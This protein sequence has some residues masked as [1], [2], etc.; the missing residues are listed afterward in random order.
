LNLAGDYMNISVLG[1]TG[2]VGT[3]TL[4]VA[5]ELKNCRVVGISG[6]K[7]I[8]LLED[9]IRKFRPQICAVADEKLA[10]ELKIKVS[11]TG[12]KVIDGEPGVCEV[13]SLDA[14][15]L[16]VCAI[17]GIA[18]LVPLLRAINSK[19]TV[20]IANK[21]PL[22]AAGKI[23]MQAARDNSVQ[24]LPLDSE[25]SAIFQ[26]LEGNDKSV[27]EKIILTA[28]GGPFFGKSRKELE[29]VTPAEAL[30]H[31]N[32][33]MGK[34][35]TIDSATLMNKGFEIIEAFWLF[36]V[37]KIE[38]IVHRESIIHSMVEFVD[39]TIL[40]QLGATSMKGPIRHALTYPSRVHVNS[41]KLDF[42]TISK[43]SFS[44]PDEKT[45]GCLKLAR[46]A[47]NLGGIMPAVLNAADEVAV[48]KFLAGEIKFLDI[49]NIV[50]NEM[51]TYQ[52]IENPTLDDILAA[53]DGIKK[54]LNFV[55]FNR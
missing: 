25:H 53:D 4:E 27:V 39:G 35:V 42:A 20:A 41:D 16:V 33:K 37:P 32:W 17:S 28:S 15:D 38:V 21:E 10:R 1:S 51:A 48:Q 44:L 50:A 26:C 40:A 12:T 22:V 2:S 34:K 6:N 5:E 30:N 36:G 54:K 14:V 43:L 23:V 52:N 29:N 7:N 9:Q 55:K 11:D 8:D 13:A 24:I 3:Q 46:E 45:F 47:L 18:G 31:P 49:E 19:K